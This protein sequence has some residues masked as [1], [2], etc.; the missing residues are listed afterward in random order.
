MGRLV[1]GQI[2][3]FGQIG[4]LGRYRCWRGLVGCLIWRWIGGYTCVRLGG[5]RRG[6]AVASSFVGLGG[7]VDQGVLDGYF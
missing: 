4:R 5:G 1:V 7:G 6:L 2:L 3:F